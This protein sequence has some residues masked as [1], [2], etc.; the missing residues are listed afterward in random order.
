[1]VALPL[2]Q[3]SRTKIYGGEAKWENSGKGGA[4]EMSI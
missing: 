1:M 4:E 3:K 2:V